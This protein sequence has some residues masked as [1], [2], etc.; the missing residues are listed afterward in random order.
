[1]SHEAVEIKLAVLEERM[2][3]LTNLFDAHVKNDQA[4]MDQLRR[5]IRGLQDWKLKLSVYATLGS[6]VG[7]LI[8]TL[9]LRLVFK[10]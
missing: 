6:T 9:L 8:S 7:G 1:M 10:I 3:Q 4:F 5:D 2:T